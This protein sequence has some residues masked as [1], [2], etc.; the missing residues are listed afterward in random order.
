MESLHDGVIPTNQA[1]AVVCEERK[2][3]AVRGYGSGG[4]ES[5]LEK[6]QDADGDVQMMNTNQDM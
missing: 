1:D 5:P 6:R 4:T 2:D 3:S